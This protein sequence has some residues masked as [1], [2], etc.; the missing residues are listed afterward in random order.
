MVRGS[1][2]SGSTRSLVPKTCKIIDPK[3]NRIE[4]VVVIIV[5]VIVMYLLIY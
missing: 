1:A 3:T 4:L 5:T 2:V